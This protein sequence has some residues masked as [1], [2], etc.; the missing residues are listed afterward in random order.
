MSGIEIEGG[1]RLAGEWEIQGSKN[2]V[3]PVLAAALL[4]AGV[5]VLTRVPDIADVR[6]S[7]EILEFLGVKTK[8]WGHTLWVDASQAAPRKIPRQMGERM[9]SSVLFLG[10]LLARF[11][12]A[13][14][15]FPG[16]CAIGR[17]PVDYHLAGLRRLGVR[18]EEGGGE[19]QA[20]AEGRLSGGVVELPYPSVGATEQLLLAACGAQGRTELR[21]AAQEPEIVTLCRYLRRAGAEISGE[22]TPVIRVEGF[23][24]SRQEI[25][26]RIPGDRI[27]AGTYLAMAAMTGGRVHI[28]G[29]SPSHLWAPLCAFR[30]MG[31]QLRLL[32]EGISLW[33]PSRLSALPFLATAPYPAFPTD[34]QSSFLAMMAVAK[35]ESCLEENV[36]ES[37]FSMA[38]QLN[39]MG[40]QIQVQG[41]RARC[42]GVER[43][44]G[45]RVWGTDLRSGAALVGAALAAE[46]TSRVEGFEHVE[47]GY[48]GMLPLLES[49]G[50]KVRKITE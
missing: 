32:P 48:Q 14:L 5:T 15:P 4:H 25:R 33:A 43:L 26:F 19:I 27:A 50:A 44:Q 6:A 24:P 39:R 23:C 42:L 22:G 10:P 8:Q 7:V 35:G 29:I 21:G 45:G 30:R 31:C 3:L 13:S 12:Q 20:E 38:G 46:G 2:A 1:C 36:F 17:R 47:R 49:L 41:R 18:L 37:R 9:R 40:A 16:G 34:L 28:R 11:G